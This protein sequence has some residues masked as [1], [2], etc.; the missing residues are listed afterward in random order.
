K[1]IVAVLLS[2]SSLNFNA[3]STTQN[4]S[5]SL[6]CLNAMHMRTNFAKLFVF[7]FLSSPVSSFAAVKICLISLTTFVILNLLV[8][9]FD[10][11]CQATNHH[12]NADFIYVFTYVQF[13]A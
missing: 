11:V 13:A 3:G 2:V 9:Y 12:F 8:C 5:E 10:L 7:I 4:V 1:S 6:I